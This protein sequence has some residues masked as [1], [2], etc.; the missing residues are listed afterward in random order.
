MA[1]RYYGEYE[2]YDERR[3]QEREDSEM[4]PSGHDGFAGMPEQVIMRAYPQPHE[5]MPE[6]LDDTR[7]GVDRQIALDES[8]KH[9]HLAPKKV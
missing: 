5:G 7:R 9:R 8:Q 3:K 1:K 2:G 6:D 4:I